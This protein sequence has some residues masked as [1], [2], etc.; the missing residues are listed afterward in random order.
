ML[1][2]VARW[3]SAVVLIGGVVSA[4]QLVE[5]DDPRLAEVDALFA[6]FQPDQPGGAVG[7]IRDGRLIYAKGFGTAN[8]D[9]GTPN[10]PQT[11]FEIA[12]ASKA[13]TSACIAAASG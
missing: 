1:R 4:D 2:D 6:N 9:Y 11:S 3:Q 13:F 10:S 5:G 8:L 7:I 12:S